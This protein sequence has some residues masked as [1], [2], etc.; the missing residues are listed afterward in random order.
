MKSVPE[1]MRGIVGALMATIGAIVAATV[2]WMA[3]HG[4]M[5]VG[6]AVPIILAAVGAGIA[7]VKGLMGLAAG[8]IVTSPTVALIGEAGPEAVIPL[9]RME[10]IPQNIT[11]NPTIHI[12]SIS[13]DIDL[14]RLTDHVSRGVAE[15]LRRRL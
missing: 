5:T 4:T 8:G 13:S 9:N 1:N 7:G 15:A 2:A 6:I 14:D 11:V 10:D 3:F 12:G